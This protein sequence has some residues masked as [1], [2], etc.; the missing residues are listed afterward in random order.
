M[1]QNWELPCGVGGKRKRIADT[2]RG[3]GG[4]WHETKHTTGP[5]LSDSCEDGEALRIKDAV[6]GSDRAGEA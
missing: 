5:P 4:D 6:L 2:G 3:H 1:W